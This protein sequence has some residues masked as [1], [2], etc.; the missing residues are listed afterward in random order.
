MLA[1]RGTVV[2]CERLASH[3]LSLFGSMSAYFG[4]YQHKAGDGV[5]TL[6]PTATVA[7]PVSPVR[8]LFVMP[9]GDKEK[10]PDLDQQ[11]RLRVVS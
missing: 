2:A 8:Y 6:T 5:P 4:E 9:S 11:R 10:E 1:K 3:G 7:L